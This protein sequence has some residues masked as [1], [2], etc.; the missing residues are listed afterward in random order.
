MYQQKIAKH[1]I[2]LNKM[3]FDNTFNTMTS[4]HTKSDKRFFR[5]VDKNPVFNDNSREA[6]YEYLVSSRKHAFDY[7]QQID[8]N[9]E[10]P[11]ACLIT[12]DVCKK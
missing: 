9:Y 3:D 4:L 7:K 5:F 1:L 6:I 12:D 11:S 8:E 2:E 10:M